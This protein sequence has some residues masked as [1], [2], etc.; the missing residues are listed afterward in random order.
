MRID[1]T[2]DTAHGQAQVHQ[3]VVTPP[4]IAPVRRIQGLNQT[5]APDGS[6]HRAPATYQDG[7]SLDL[8]PEAREA[9]RQA[10]LE[11]LAQANKAAAPTVPGEEASP[12]VRQAQNAE[13]AKEARAREYARSEAAAQMQEQEQAR[14]A[15][16]AGNLAFR[17]AVYS[18]RRGPDGRL[19]AEAS[20]VS[21]D[22]SGVPGDPEATLRKAEQLRRAAMAPG[23][24]SPQDLAI[25]AL[26][27]AMAARA[28]HEIARQEEADKESPAPQIDTRQ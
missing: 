25:A 26:A 13:E 12:Q 21:V 18:Y 24:P 3:R 22:T 23:N 2:V 15:A 5:T 1:H 17:G 16:A 11:V 10:A 4:V 7:I 14:A 27:A 19:Y 28:R 6:E 8:S 20:D 9:A